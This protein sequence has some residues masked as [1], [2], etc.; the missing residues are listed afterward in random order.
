MNSHLALKRQ[1][2]TIKQRVYPECDKVCLAVK[3]MTA[4]CY[5]FEGA[6]NL[7]KAEV[8]KMSEQAGCTKLIFIEWQ[9]VTRDNVDQFNGKQG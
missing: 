7:T 4:D 5:C 1:I 9:R 3:E 8:E 2:K 6:S